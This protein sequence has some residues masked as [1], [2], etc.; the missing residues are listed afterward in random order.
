VMAMVT[1]W[2]NE[3]MDAKVADHSTENIATAMASL[4]REARVAARTL[5]TT[6]STTKNAALRAMAARLRAAHAEILE[7]NAEDL[8]AAREGERSPSF[9]DRLTLTPERIEAMA[10]GIEDI[11]ALA[12]PVGE[13]IASWE[14][15][16]GL[17]IER[18]RTPLGV[19]GIIFESRPNVTADAGALCLKAGNAAILR[20][21]SES[22]R[23]A[24]AIHACLAGGLSDAGLPQTAIQL[25]PTRSRDAVGRCSPASMETST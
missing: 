22:Y 9:I 3:Q 8:Q 11:A 25:V 21:G 4:G 15:P 19:I 16:N 2:S 17:R 12:D 1:K 10:S 24:K 5:A 14:R 23:S 13:V 6:D 20:P 7:A 18:V